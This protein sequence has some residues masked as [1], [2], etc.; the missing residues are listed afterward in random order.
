MTVDNVFVRVYR[1]E[2]VVTVLASKGFATVDYL[3]LLSHVLVGL[4]TL[5][6]NKQRTLSWAG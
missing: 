2:C 3:F 4:R 1:T 6:V 5:R